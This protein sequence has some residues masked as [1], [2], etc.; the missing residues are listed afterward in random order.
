MENIKPFELT[1]VS[2]V[3]SE[4]YTM[5]VCRKCAYKETYGSKGMVKAMKESRIEKESD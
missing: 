3:G 5:S 1:F 4:D 2:F